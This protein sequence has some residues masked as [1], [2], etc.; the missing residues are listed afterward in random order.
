[1]AAGGCRRPLIQSRS[2]SLLNYLP[3]RHGGLKELRASGRSSTRSYRMRLYPYLV[4]VSG[5][6]STNAGRMRQTASLRGRRATPAAVSTIT[7]PREAQPKMGSFES[8]FF[9]RDIDIDTPIANI[10]P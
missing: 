10:Y 7:A 8:S 2:E 1:M 3:T 6:L 4:A 9:S 5:Q